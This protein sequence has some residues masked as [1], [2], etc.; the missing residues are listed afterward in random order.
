MATKHKTE[1]TDVATIFLPLRLARSVSCK[2]VGITA[3]PVFA[4]DKV[5][6]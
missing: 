4:A 6:K 5:A 2:G 3:D 1:T